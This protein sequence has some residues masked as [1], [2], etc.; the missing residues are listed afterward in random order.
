MRS[1]F[2]TAAKRMGARFWLFMWKKRIHA[3]FLI[4]REASGEEPLAGLA[5]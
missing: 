2:W 1:R 3:I 5:L 4:E